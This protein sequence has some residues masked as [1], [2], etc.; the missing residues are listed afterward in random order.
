MRLLVVFYSRTGTTRRVA[1]T[2]SETLR[3]DI[4][5]I[6]DEKSRE[7]ILGWLRAGRDAG[8]SSLT[9]I[10]EIENDPASY[11]VVII[12]TP[13]WNGTVS[14]P[15]RTYIHQQKG[16][17]KRL[18]FFLTQDS[19]LSADRESRTFQEMSAVAGKQPIALLSLRRGD[20]A[21]GDYLERLTDFI[22]KLQ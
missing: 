13:V 21:K 19:P 7:G 3:C 10:K 14:T 1:E 2:L 11:D 22:G 6:F 15:I 4:E 20:V 17:F 12:G 18:A 5:E 8:A 16:S 9:E